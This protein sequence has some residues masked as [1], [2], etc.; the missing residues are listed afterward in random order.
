MKRTE[1]KAREKT[2]P[3]ILETVIALNKTKAR[4]W[5]DVAERIVAPTRQI[6]GVPLW[7]INKYTNEGDTIVVPGKVLGN[8]NIDHKVTVAALSYSQAAL[9]KLKA[10]KC[11]TLT[12]RELSKK[13]PKGSGVKIIG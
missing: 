4:V 13:N 3:F 9:E 6:K 10:A 7:R 2:N 1:K 5:R 8:G 12:I 11:K